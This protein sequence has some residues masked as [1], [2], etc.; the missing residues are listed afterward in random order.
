M[1]RYFVFK[2]LLEFMADHSEV[3][4]AHI[5]NYADDIEITGEVDGQEVR[6]TVRFNDK[7][8]KET[9]DNVG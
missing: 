7:E 5:K 6:I 9:C 3:T 2:R 8:D 4:N 1:D